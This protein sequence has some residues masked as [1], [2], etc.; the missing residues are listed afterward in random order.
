MTSNYSDNVSAVL[1]A[2]SCDDL[3]WYPYVDYTQ[4]AS[5]RQV[6]IALYVTVIALSLCGNAMVI[7][8]VSR[9][10]HMRTV[11]NCYLVNLAVSDSLVTACVMPL[12][13]LEYTA[14]ACEWTM[15]RS[16]SLCSLLYYAFPVFVF[17]S[18]LTLVAISI[19]R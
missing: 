9:Y 11:T 2:T 10:R 19:E 6:F 3:Q 1:T 12:K 18:I 15:L 5:V 13:A 14:S 8:T 4:L 16:N 7:M 17:T